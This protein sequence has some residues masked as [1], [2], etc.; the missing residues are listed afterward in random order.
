MPNSPQPSSTPDDLALLRQA[1]EGVPGA[2]DQLLARHESAMRDV[3]RFTLR[4]RSDV[5]VD[6]ALQDAR[7][8]LLRRLDR[9]NPQYPFA[10]FA[11]A[12]ARTMARRYLLTRSPTVMAGPDG[13][14]GEEGGSVEPRP[15]QLT[16]LPEPL[17]AAIGVNR[18]AAPDEAPA[19]SPRFLELLET[20]LRYGGY[21]HQQMVF[22]FSVL[23]WG[24]AKR[25]PKGEADNSLRQR[26]DKVPITGDADRVVREIGPQ[27]LAVSSTCLLNELGEEL[28]LTQDYLR[29]VRRPLD[30]RLS[31]TGEEL[32][33]RDV[34]SARQFTGLAKRITAACCLEDYWGTDPRRSVSDW[35]RGVKERVRKI[36]L[37][38]EI[39]R[40][41]PFPQPEGAHNP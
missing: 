3:I 17:Q 30:Y 24:V 40:A 22:G 15:D 38:P 33:A 14:S 11:R 2:F 21:P 23:L 10:V 29:R 5:S 39:V 27:A 12:L 4:S 19:A 16:A 31:L 36:Y 32:F 6:E 26:P 8:Y 25:R 37:N 13:T 7:L 35:T 34:S 1:R 9:F 41:L 18:F 28:C 20:F